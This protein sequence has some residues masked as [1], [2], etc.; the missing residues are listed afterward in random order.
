MSSRS[1]AGGVAAGATETTEHTINVPLARKVLEHLETVPEDHLQSV[2]A[3]VKGSDDIEPTI[4][5]IDQAAELALGACGTVG[6]FAGWT[7]AID[8]HVVGTVGE[9]AGVV[10]DLSP[11]L[12][13]TQETYKWDDQVEPDRRFAVEGEQVTAE[14]YAKD[15]LG[16][17]QLQANTLFAGHRTRRDLRELLS[18]WTNGEIEA[19]R[20]E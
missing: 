11:D 13:I 17:T 2:W 1:N 15:A 6:C 7:A 4:T 12:V 18:E 3:H 20:P 10:I 8:G 16:L 5:T 9:L 19:E 14:E